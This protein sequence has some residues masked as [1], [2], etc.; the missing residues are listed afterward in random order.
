[1]KVRGMRTISFEAE[2]TS[3]KLVP[4]EGDMIVSRSRKFVLSTGLMDKAGFRTMCDGDHSY[5]EHRDTGERWMVKLIGR[6]YYLRV[7][8][9]VSQTVG[10]VDDMES[11]S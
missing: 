5:M 10:G 2:A 7:R 8:V 1:M 3:G 6:T 11:S 4:L 9:R